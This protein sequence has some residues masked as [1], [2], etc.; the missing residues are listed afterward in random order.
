MRRKILREIDL[1]EVGELREVKRPDRVLVLD[2]GSVVVVE[3]TGR[4][5]P[6]DVEKHLSL[7]DALGGDW[8]KLIGRERPRSVTCVIHHRRGDAV[9][10]ARMR[11]REVLKKF[12]RRGARVVAV[13]CEREFRE[14]LGL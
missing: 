1:D 3:E 7:L 8:S 6:E 14:K 11:S 10:Y 13:E 4:P 5:R 9:F 12:R 2:D